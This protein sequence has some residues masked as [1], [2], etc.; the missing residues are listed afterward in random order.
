M[1][2]VPVR[3]RCGADPQQALVRGRGCHQAT[4]GEIHRAPVVRGAPRV[5]QRVACAIVAAG[6]GELLQAAVDAGAEDVLV[7]LSSMTM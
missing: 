6:K 7:I 1:P 5:R 3:M 2:Q 4:R